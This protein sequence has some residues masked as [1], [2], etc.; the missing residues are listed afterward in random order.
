MKTL[1]SLV[2]AFL[3]LSP[4]AFGVPF[5]TVTNV[6]VT[7]IHPTL[8]SMGFTVEDP[9][10]TIRTLQGAGAAQAEV[11]YIADDLGL[12]LDAQVQTSSGG[13][14]P[15]LAAE[16]VF[17]F[18]TT[19]K[20]EIFTTIDPSQG[21]TIKTFNGG[22]IPALAPAGTHTIR[23]KASVPTGI[24]GI[25]FE[26]AEDT[27]VIPDPDPGHE[28][29]AD[30]LAWRSYANGLWDV[31]ANWKP[32]FAPTLLDTVCFN[33]IPTTV[34]QRTVPLPDII[35]TSSGNE[36]R[37]VKQ[38]EIA[39]SA[40][41]L[42]DFSLATGDGATTGSTLTI[43]NGGRLTLDATASLPASGHVNFSTT[44]AI[45][46][47][48]AAQTIA[49]GRRLA[50]SEMTIG[51]NVRWQDA[52]L[53]V[54]VGRTMNARLAIESRF[55]DPATNNTVGGQMLLGLATGVRGI[56]D[57]FGSLEADDILVGAARRSVG[58]V[59][60]KKGGTLGS[61]DGLLAS[62]K[63]S[64]AGV[65]VSDEVVDEPGTDRD[66]TS[67]GQHSE[68]AMTDLAMSGLANGGA[69]STEGG[70]SQLFISSGGVVEA[71]QA[72]LGNIRATN[73]IPAVEKATVFVVGHDPVDREVS[74]FNIS[75]PLIVGPFSPGEVNVLDGGQVRPESVAIGS[76]GRVFLQRAA[77]DENDALIAK[78]RLQVFTGQGPRADGPVTIAGGGFI[79]MSSGTDL[80]CGDLTIGGIRRTA[81]A[82]CRI[83][84]SETT[85]ELSKIETGNIS[86]GNLGFPGLLDLNLPTVEAEQFISVDL[87]S[88]IRG[89]GELKFRNPAGQLTNRGSIIVPPG[90]GKVLRVGGD[91]IQPSPGKLVITVNPTN[92]APS[93]PFIVE[94]TTVQLNG[95]VELRFSGQRRP[96]T[97]QVYALIRADNATSITNTAT[98]K[99]TGAIARFD[100]IVEPFG[101]AL[102]I[103]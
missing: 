50:L 97:G 11:Q 29:V 91:Y 74:F 101:V 64:N 81:A 14:E 9:P 55:T 17:T 46:G 90:A 25:T 51:P 88:A 100:V 48:G 79:S 68:W 3:A 65:F 89:T 16:I 26:I 19:K 75:G 102:V 33:I 47:L 99:I 87:G 92:V 60:V 4:F 2:C 21:P 27:S 34:A 95:T 1:P 85:Q 63:G 13:N 42:R 22:P 96:R 76:R 37:E 71:N 15:G 61:Q 7:A 36:A 62:K 10:G 41:N 66:Y 40:V 24:I 83:D 70:E 5:L 67:Q 56:L 52:S 93:A 72:S 44:N 43:G 23:M 49:P 20:I 73:G 45:I 31:A 18:T 103:K 57:V 94:G 39:R 6:E 12:F 38:I 28:N 78:S 32:S 53:F 77:V 86:V 58:T 80:L 84:D 35:V 30:K 98:F 8:E 82:L 54:I 59:F 69:G